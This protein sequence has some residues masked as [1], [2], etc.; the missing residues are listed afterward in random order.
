MIA[1]LG[2]FEPLHFAFAGHAIDQSMFG[3]DAS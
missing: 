2:N 3:R 1:A